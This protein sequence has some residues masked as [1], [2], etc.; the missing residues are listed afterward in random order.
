MDE[1]KERDRNVNKIQHSAFAKAYSI[2]HI[3]KNALNF[4]VRLIDRTMWS[5]EIPPRFPLPPTLSLLLDIKPSY[6]FTTRWKK[7]SDKIDKK[8]EVES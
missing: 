7:K 2:L 4:K 6:K 8:N 3:L 1:K 5:F